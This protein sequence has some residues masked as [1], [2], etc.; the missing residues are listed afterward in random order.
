MENEI[1]R[2][3]VRINKLTQK[4]EMMNIRLINK[5]K[6]KLRKLRGEN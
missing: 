6:R 1:K 2:I 3:E 4:G 5:L